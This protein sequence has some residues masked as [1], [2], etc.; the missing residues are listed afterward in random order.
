MWPLRKPKGRVTADVL[1]TNGQPFENKVTKRIN[2]AFKK[3]RERAGKPHK[4]RQ[5]GWGM[6]DY[7][8]WILEESNITV[9]GGVT[10]DGITQGDGSHLDGETITLETNDWLEIEITDGGSD[11]DFDDNDGNQRL[12]G[13]QTIDGVTYADGTRVEAEYFIELEDGEGNVYQA[14]AFNVRNSSPAYATVEGLAFVGPPQDWPP[15][16]EPLLVTLSLEGPGSSGQPSIPAEDLVIPCFT[17]GTLIT[18]P[19]GQ[20]AVEDLSTGDLILTLDNGFRPIVWINNVSL[21]AGQLW[22]D[23]SMRPIRVL[24]HA[25]GPDQPNRDMLLSP[26]HRVL[27]RGWRTELLFGVSEGLAAV[28]HLVNDHSVRRAKDVDNVTYIHFMFDRHEVVCADGLWAE[29]FLPG[30]LAVSSLEEGPRQELLKLFP[31]LGIE[32]TPDVTSARPILKR[33]EAALFA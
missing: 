31:E 24:A 14:I 4:S 12:D 33:W 30:P 23:P 13:A 7:S 15:V 32:K 9:S 20:R 1:E 21:D 28:R 22:R 26:Q 16:G 3:D 5:F 18:T 6:A 10:L 17:P 25:F 19:E 11:D 27:L 29:S 2:A 8:V